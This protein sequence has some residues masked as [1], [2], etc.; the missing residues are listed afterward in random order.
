MCVCVS[1]LLLLGAV[2]S[3]SL[4]LYLSTLLSTSPLR[5]AQVRL[6]LTLPHL[7][8]PYLTLPY[9]TSPL[10]VAQVRPYLTSAPVTSTA[11]PYLTVT[12]PLPYLTLP[13]LTSPLRVAPVRLC[14]FGTIQH[15]RRGLLLLAPLSRGHAQQHGWPHRRRER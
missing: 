5:V 13:Y 7:T 14:D 15:E 3:T 1:T 2:L 9:L 4:P 12:L 6:Y 8:S 11:M 10:R